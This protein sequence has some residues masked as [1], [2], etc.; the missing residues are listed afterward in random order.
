MEEN[1]SSQCNTYLQD[2][3]LVP[4][5]DCDLSLSEVLGWNLSGYTHVYTQRHALGSESLTHMHGSLQAC[6]KP[7]LGH[8]KFG[9]WSP[10]VVCKWRLTVEVNSFLGSLYMVVEMSQGDVGCQTGLGMWF[11]AA[12]GLPLPHWLPASPL[13]GM[14]RMIATTHDINSN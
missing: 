13:E 11:L 1:I 12:L 10:L 7:W 5:D 9:R 2:V 8:Q 4:C 6:A 14:Q 3:I